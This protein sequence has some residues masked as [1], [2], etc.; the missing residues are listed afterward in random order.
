M[1]HCSICG[2]AYSD[3][4]NTCPNCH[5]PLNGGT[6]SKPPVQ[7]PKPPVQPPT[8]PVQQ[9]YKP[10]VEPTPAPIR[11]GSTFQ[12]GAASAQSGA[13]PVRSGTTSTQSSAA[14]VRSGS[15]PVQSGTNRTTPAAARED[16]LMGILG[17]LLF[18]LGGGVIQVILIYVDVV[19]SLAGLITFVLAYYGYEKCSG[20]RYGTSKKAVWICIPISLLMLLLGTLVGGAMLVA[21]IGGVTVSDAF[22]LIFENDDLL[23]A[24]G[25]VFGKTV[26]FWGISVVIS[27]IRG[28]TKK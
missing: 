27:L 4:I 17:A 12:S 10:P 23:Q 20:D 11:S 6:A 5:A 2:R 7:Q 21:K 18:A 3:L 19:A 25:K 13:A 16:V 24:I 1:K 28:G 9:P 14:P 22:R 8:P 26:A 15:T